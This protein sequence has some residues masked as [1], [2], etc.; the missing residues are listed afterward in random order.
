MNA[1]EFL[2][3]NS[4]LK[5]KE[6]VE[7]SEFD[8]DFE[9]TTYLIRL[10]NRHWK[11]SKI[12]YYIFCAIDGTRNL[13]DIKEYLYTEHSINIGEQELETIIDKAFVQNGLLEGTTASTSPPENKMLWGKFT[14]I[15]PNIIKK[16]RFL[17]FMFK[18][19]QMIIFSSIV[20]LWMLYIFSTN[21]NISVVNEM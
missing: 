14:L 19:S 20:L 10:D 3:K 15:S 5:M 21:S 17:N 4:I 13:S 6:E 2:T 11:V 1:N 18:K 16:F 9:K 8:G 12:I 7:V